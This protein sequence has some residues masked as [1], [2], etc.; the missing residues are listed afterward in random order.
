[1]SLTFLDIFRLRKKTVGCPNVQNQLKVYRFPIRNERIER[2]KTMEVN[3]IQNISFKHLMD[4]K[5][6]RQLNHKSAGLLLR[7]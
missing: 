1:M 7:K 2:M 5:E 4:I 6:W 3:E